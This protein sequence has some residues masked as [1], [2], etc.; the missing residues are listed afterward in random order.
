MSAQPI[1]ERAAARA[2]QQ[3]LPYAGAVTPQE[4]HDLHE[5]RQATIVDVRTRSEFEQVGHVPGTELIEWRRDGEPEPDPRFV[6]R[7]A[8]SHPDK[9]APLLLLCRSGVR[10]HYAA[11]LAARAGFSRVYNILS[12][13]EQGWRPAGLPW[14]KE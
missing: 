5:A 6:E 12:G 10:S 4:A 2:G 8:A 9:T 3:G 14:E 11:E 7:L 13:F 1:F